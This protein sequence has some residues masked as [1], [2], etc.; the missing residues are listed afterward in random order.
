MSRIFMCLARLVVAV[1]VPVSGQVQNGIQTGPELPKPG[2]TEGG[3]SPGFVNFD[4]AP[5]TCSFS[6]TVA[7]T[8]EYAAFGVTFSGPGGNDGGAVLDECS[9]FG[10]TGYSS[11]NFLAFNTGASNSD[12]GVPQGPETMTFDPLINSLTLNCG[13]NAGGTVTLECFDGGGASLGSDTINVSSVL[14]PLTVADS[15]IASCVVSFT[16]ALMVCDDLDFAQVPV[17]LQTFA[18]E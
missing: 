13:A 12:G 3:S 8:N 11:P 9:N 14:S 6:D 15:G 16:A 10:V 1:S 4:D 17:E 18:V 5:S 2:Q 7:T